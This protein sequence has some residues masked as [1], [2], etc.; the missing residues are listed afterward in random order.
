[1]EIYIPPYGNYNHNFHNSHEWVA[2]LS[3]LRLTYKNI[4]KCEASYGSYSKYKVDKYLFLYMR[5]LSTLID[6]RAK[7]KSLEKL[8]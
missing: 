6:A 7:R 5:N 1:M 2:P 4:I 8:W 3:H